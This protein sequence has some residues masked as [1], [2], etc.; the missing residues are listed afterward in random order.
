MNKNSLLIIPVVVLVLTACGKDSGG[1]STPGTDV[2]IQQMEPQ[3][4]EGKYDAILR[5][6]NTS[7][8]GFI[9]SGRTIIEV[10]E[11]DFTVI[12]YLEDD[13]RVMHIQ[14]IHE[15][16]R[17]PTLQDD[18]NKD[19]FIDAVEM[20]K[21]TGNVLVPLDGDLNSQMAGQDFYPSGKTFTYNES[22]S[23]ETL[24]QDLYT[25]DLPTNSSLVKLQ[26]GAPLNL[27]GRVVIIHGTAELARVPESVKTMNNLPRNVSIPIT[28]GVIK[29]IN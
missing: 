7:V 6:L 13:S 17:C 21:A 19:G 5:P 12:S 9:P 20:K 22:A 4:F 25:K 14:S 28:C 8:S 29:R 16:V 23:A 10:K 3:K 2:S 1:S 27:E 18:A 26:A 24:L 15:G 11:G